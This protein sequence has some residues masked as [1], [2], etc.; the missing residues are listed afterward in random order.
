MKT[1]TTEEAKAIINKKYFQLSSGDKSRVLI[2][3]NWECDNQVRTIYQDDQ[4]T[5]LLRFGQLLTH[6]VVS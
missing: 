3:A 4:L 5:D 6:L 1:L 2:Y